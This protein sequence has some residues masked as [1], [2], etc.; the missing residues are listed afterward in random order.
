MVRRAGIT[1]GIVRSRRHGRNRYRRR[2]RVRRGLWRSLWIERL[3][4][5]RGA[6]YRNWSRS[7]FRRPEFCPAK[8]AGDDQED[9]DRPDEN[10]LAPA[11]TGT[12]LHGGERRSRRCGP[13]VR[14]N[15]GLS[16]SERHILKLVFLNLPILRGRDDFFRRG[17]RGGCSLRSGRRH[18]RK[19]PP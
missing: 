14:G 6:R 2:T 1:R 11:R 16:R 15:R 7:R 12:L 8:I 3:S 4:R 17:R 10:L 5:L 13:R 18:S 19:E 9:C